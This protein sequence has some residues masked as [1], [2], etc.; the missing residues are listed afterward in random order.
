MMRIKDDMTV[1][2]VLEVIGREEDISI[3]REKG[4]KALAD[5]LSEE[6]E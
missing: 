1:Q 3:V 5:I 2:E 4:I 6:V